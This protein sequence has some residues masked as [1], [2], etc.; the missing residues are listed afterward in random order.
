M[1][2]LFNINFRREMFRRERERVVQRAVTLGIWVAFF[3][4]MAVVLGLYA[5]NWVALDEQI[6]TAESRTE[7]MKTSPLIHE[8]LAIGATELAQVES[9]LQN[10]RRWRRRMERLS[11]ILPADAALTSVSVNPNNLQSEQDQ[12]Q[13]VIVGVM[14]APSGQDRIGSVMQFVSALR[15]DSV[16]SPGYESIKLAKSSMSEGPPP[17][18]DFTIE[19]R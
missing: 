14:R 16:F 6:R 3:G 8:R 17:V 15:A 18:I 9:A 11:A 10:P 19:C 1:T 2:L 7:R 13:L 4:V 12:N 5:L